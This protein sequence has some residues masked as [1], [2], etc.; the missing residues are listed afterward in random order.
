MILILRVFKSWEFSPPWTS[1]KAMESRTS[2]GLCL[3]AEKRELP[4]TK[5]CMY[6]K[7]STLLNR[8]WRTIE[9]TLKHVCRAF[10]L[11]QQHLWLAWK[12]GIKFNPNWHWPFLGTELDLF[13][14][15]THRRGGEKEEL[16]RE[17]LISHTDWT[18]EIAGSTDGRP[19]Q[20]LFEQKV[21]D[22]KPVFQVGRSNGN[23]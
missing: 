5:S 23:I 20:K 17:R 7:I 22:N 18:T 12:W 15:K 11:Q 21:A 1:T 9:S 19:L 13:K 16:Q 14:K 8:R 2:V 4:A 10:L 6:K 3:D